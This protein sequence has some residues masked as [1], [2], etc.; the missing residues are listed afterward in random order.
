MPPTRRD[1]SS[2]AHG[3]AS[4]RAPSSR[5]GARGLSLGARIPHTRLFAVRT[6]C[7][8]LLQLRSASLAALGPAS[9]TAMPDYVRHASAVPNDPYFASGQSYLNDDPHASR[10][11]TSVTARRRSSSP[12]STPAS[13]PVARPR[14]PGPSRPQLRSRR[15]RSRR[16]ENL[17]WTRT[18][19][20]TTR[21]SVTGHWSRAIAAATTNNGLGIAGVAW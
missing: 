12:S 5:P 11:G 17:V 21:R 10:H 16:D 8:Q 18:T 3:P 6:N 9:P 13:P 14:R 2:S 15:G 1:G 7:A 4:H 19:Q 20:A